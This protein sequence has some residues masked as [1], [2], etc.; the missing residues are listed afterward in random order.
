MTS[1]I[2]IF[3]FSL[4]NVL[5]VESLKAKIFS[6]EELAKYDGKVNII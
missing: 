3:V 1:I 5:G 6:L 2:L 4:I